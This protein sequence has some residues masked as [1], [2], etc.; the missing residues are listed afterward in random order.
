MS[1]NTPYSAKHVHLLISSYHHWTGKDLISPLESEAETFQALYEA[2]FALASHDTAE[3]PMFNYG[4]LAA[5]R[6][7]EMDW[8]TLLSHPSKHSAEPANREERARLLARTTE[9]G[10]IDDYKGV[11]ISS[12]GKRFR[13]EE[14][15]IWNVIDAD[16]KYYGQAA[17]LHKWSEI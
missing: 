7:F 3:D 15:F 13:I 5:Q 11:R 9:H 14:A 12:T 16:D 4:N 10:F 17:L 6:L 1:T 2:P 8:S